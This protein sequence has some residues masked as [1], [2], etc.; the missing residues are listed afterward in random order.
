MT[1]E[2]AAIITYFIGI[3]IIDGHGSIAV[4]LAILVLIILSGKEYLTKTRERFSREELG[5]SLK[6][7]V[8]ALVIL[9]LLPNVN[10]SILEIIR[11][12]YSGALDWNH[13]VITAQFFNP[14]KIWFF[15]VLMA[16][17]EYAGFILSRIIG[18]RG[19]IVA[20]GAIG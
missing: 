5:D 14:Y 3:I 17:I 16:G 20:S 15:V 12:F 1:S 7:A 19:G 10:F 4:I 2:L 8:I 13:P 6:F 9:P 11:W 18:S